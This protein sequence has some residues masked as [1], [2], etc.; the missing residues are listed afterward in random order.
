MIEP[1]YVET[2]DPRY[3]LVTTTDHFFIDTDAVSEH[4]D[5]RGFSSS[6]AP[7]QVQLTE[8]RGIKPNTLGT[9]AKM[10]TGSPLPFGEEGYGE[11]KDVDGTVTMSV[12]A[13]DPRQA[14]KTLIRHI[15]YG[16][17]LL[18]LQSVVAPNIDQDASQRLTLKYIAAT[19]GLAFLGAVIHPIAGATIVG[20]SL[21]YAGYTDASNPHK[22]SARAAVKRYY[23]PDN[24][25]VK[26]A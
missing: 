1:R 17:N 19:G 14:T 22:R 24:L 11:C 18:M 23:N 8:G 12:V 9:V 15:D 4:L 20:S 6:T 10:M 25:L 13:Y 26:P 21:A 2:W 7:M 16:W 5:E 3:D